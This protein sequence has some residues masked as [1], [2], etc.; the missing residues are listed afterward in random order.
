MLCY[1]SCR[2]GDGWIGRRKRVSVFVCARVCLSLSAALAACFP[3]AAGLCGWMVDG[4]GDW[5]WDGEIVEVGAAGELRPMAM[6]I[7]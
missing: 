2:R 7:S 6:G 1:A 4:V 5:D 3:L